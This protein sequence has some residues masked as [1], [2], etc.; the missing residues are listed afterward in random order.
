MRNQVAVYDKYFTYHTSTSVQKNNNEKRAALQSFAIGKSIQATDID[1]I[2]KAIK[3]PIPQNSPDNEENEYYQRN[4]GSSPIDPSQIQEAVQFLDNIIQK[5]DV[6]GDKMEVIN[7]FKLHLLR[8]LTDGNQPNA[9]IFIIGKGG[10]GKTY[11]S[12]I[13]SKLSTI[14]SPKKSPKSAG[15]TQTGVAA[16]TAEGSTIYR[17][18]IPCTTKANGV[19][20]NGKPFQDLKDEDLLKLRQLTGFYP[21]TITL[22][23]FDEMP[24]LPLHDFFLAEKRIRQ[25]F[26]LVAPDYPWAT[27]ANSNRL[28]GNIDVCCIGDILQHTPVGSH[29]LAKWI[30]LYYQNELYPN[31]TRANQKSTNNGPDPILCLSPT[32]PIYEAIQIITNATYFELKEQHR[33]NDDEHLK[34]FDKIYSFQKLSIDDF[35]PYK[36]LS[37]N[38]FH[39]DPSWLNATV[40]TGTNYE[41]KWFEFCQAR[42]YA[43]A[44]RT[45]IIRWK[46]KYVQR[47]NNPDPAKHPIHN[48]ENLQYQLF[49]PNCN[50]LFL[51]N[52]NVEKGLVNGSDVK[53]ITIILDSKD[54]QKQFEKEVRAAPPGKIITLQQPPYCI[55]I[56]LFFDEPQDTSKEKKMKQKKR[57]DWKSRH[58]GDFIEGFH[59]KLVVPIKPM[60]GEG[61]KWPVILKTEEGPL[62]QCEE[63]LVF[64]YYLSFAITST[65]AQSRTIPR[66]IISLL[67]REIQQTINSKIEI[68]DLNVN[69]GRAKDSI[70][71]IRL[72]LPPNH[73]HDNLNYLTNL[74]YKADIQ[75]FINSL[76]PIG[77]STVQKRFDEKKYKEFIR[78]MHDEQNNCKQKKYRRKWAKK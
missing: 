51:R 5:E 47:K 57:E 36:L 73:T 54:L 28:F 52:V 12:K 30:E 24:T 40:L 56:E 45:V 17:L 49:I 67:Q 61:K 25:V 62:L 11:L 66:V 4:E 19:D 8:R 3:K 55:L 63:H 78:H 14:L 34:I 50:A 20:K 1:S 48:N 69:L 13:L 15:F 46:N 71:N 16:V 77:D 2:F 76:T 43:S 21:G 75:N 39:H 9:C 42:I 29:S 10:T 65:K 64:P 74:E 41:R 44:N 33:C 18:R 70:D 32:F 60:S 37:E 38:D 35:R 26:P 58:A 7:W 53:L 72:L 68:N 22:V 59:N 6:H 23:I 31:E 27:L